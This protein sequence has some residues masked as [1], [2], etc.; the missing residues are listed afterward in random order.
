MKKNSPILSRIDP[1]LWSTSNTTSV[2]LP[3]SS[4]LNLKR[5][6]VEFDTDQNQPNKRPKLLA[7]PD[8]TGNEKGKGREI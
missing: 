2:V 4:N 3:E 7:S 5:L 1:E 6:F 8:P